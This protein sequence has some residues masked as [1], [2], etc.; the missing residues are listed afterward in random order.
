KAINENILATKQG[1]EQDA[2]AV[3]ESVETVGVVESGNLTAR[4]TANPRNPQLIEL[5]NVLNRLLDALQAR[6]GSDM[7]EIQRVF[8]S[9]KSLDFTTEVKDANG[10][11]E[12]TTNALGDEIVKMLKQSSD[13]ANHLASESSKLQSAVQNLTSSS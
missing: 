12:V 5:K 9:Y 8:N 7:N 4:I 10:A 11:V 6:V 2:K 13:F 1:L 3:K